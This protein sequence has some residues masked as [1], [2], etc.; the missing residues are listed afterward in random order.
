[1]LSS[2]PI[3][4]GLPEFMSWL[5]GNS[6]L[7]SVVR[8]TRESMLLALLGKLV[9]IGPFVPCNETLT[10]DSASGVFNSKVSD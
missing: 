8:M 2:L 7:P 9:K 1:M 10:W 5:K 4:N 6:G 3:P